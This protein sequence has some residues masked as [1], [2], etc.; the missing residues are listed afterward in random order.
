[1]PV[2]IISATSWLSISAAEPDRPPDGVGSGVGLG[3]GLG[4]GE[5]GVGLG[6]G[7]GEPGVGLGEPGLVLSPGVAVAGS[8]VTPGEAVVS[9]PPLGDGDGDADSPGLTSGVFDVSGLFGE[10][11]LSGPP[12]PALL[13]G[14]VTPFPAHEAANPIIVTINTML[15]IL[16][17]VII[18]VLS[19]YI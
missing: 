19:F 13:S 10:T 8:S 14:P 11:E 12:L 9:G 6:L 5:P 1:M 2:A 18:P 3:L 16:L 17:K 7:L 15:R 4:L